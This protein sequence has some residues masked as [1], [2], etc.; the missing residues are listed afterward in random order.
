MG[1]EIP[2]V[3]R[4]AVLVLHGLGE[5]RHSMQPLVDHLRDAVD[6]TVMAVGYASPR[7]GIDEHAR[8]LAAVVGSLPKESLVSFVGHSLGGL[9][10]RRWMAMAD[11]DTVAR[12][13]RVVML[14]SPNRGSDLARM[15]SRIWLVSL[16]ADGAARELAIDWDRIEGSLAVP[17]C[18]FGI[19]AGGRGD[20]RGY[21]DLLEGDDDAVVRV[22]E[23][24]LEGADDFLLLPVRHAAMMKSEPVQRATAE[25]LRSGRFTPADRP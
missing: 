17:P 24:R 9:V 5:G 16:V 4:P 19:V 12:V 10:I 18:P 14:G 1:G 22:E 7:A 2:P 3:D 11:R 23:T 6:A 25:F 15:A 8:S 21:S 13:G 20:G